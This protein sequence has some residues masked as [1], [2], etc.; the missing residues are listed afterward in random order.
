MKMFFINNKIF[1]FKYLN[2]NLRNIVNNE[3]KYF[4]RN[5]KKMNNLKLGNEN[6]TIN[7]TNKKNILED[8]YIKK[9]DNNLNLKDNK[10]SDLNTNNN[11]YFDNKNQKNDKHYNIDFSKDFEKYDNL[12]NNKQENNKFTK[13]KSFKQNYNKSFDYKEDF[14]RND[15]KKNK[16]FKNNYNRNNQD[17][18]FYNSNKYKNNRKEFRN[19]EENEEFDPVGFNKRK[20]KN[21][22][23]EKERIDT[24]RKHNKFEKNDRFS[25]NKHKYNDNFNE[26]RTKYKDFRNNNKNTYNNIYNKES[27]DITKDYNQDNMFIKK[28][29]EENSRYVKSK[30]DSYLN[31]EE[32]KE[33]DNNNIKN[34]KKFSFERKVDNKYNL[35]ITPNEELHANTNSMY[36][37]FDYLYGSHVVKA[38]LH[39]NLRN[40]IE[41]YLLENYANNPSQ[42]IEEILNLCK[43]NNVNIIPTN[44]SKLERLSGGKPNNGVV[45]K[46]EKKQYIDV[47]TIS[48]LYK[49]LINRYELPKSEN[50]SILEIEKDFNYINKN[51]DI[52]NQTINEGG[53]LVILIDQII[54]P[55]NFASI[56]RTAFYLGVDAIVVNKPNRLSLSP[57]ISK[58]SSGSLECMDIYCTKIKSFIKDAFV[59]NWTIIGSTIETNK[60]IIIKKGKELSSNEVENNSVDE[61]SSDISYENKLKMFKDLDTTYIDDIPI[62]KNSKVLLIFGSMSFEDNEDPKSKDN[63]NSYRCHY[64]T[65]IKSSYNSQIKDNLKYN[66]V[67]NLNV[68]VSAGIIINKV[69][70]MLTKI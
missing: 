67:D 63:C 24:N 42:S 34:S 32:N 19:K 38:T 35:L 60:D 68:G 37:S 66:V 6:V 12:S 27:N 21:I 39:T 53:K 65:E 33:S 55:Q 4:A 40:H 25:E 5:I 36:S 43:D 49:Y 20:K 23:S 47:K 14:D 44:K 62:N 46:T 17:N 54:D 57:L 18:E 26:E 8:I 28:K 31:N 30:I 10:F 45:L 22:L 29:L 59:N 3:V 13:H 51:K 56:L 50:K 69:K 48:S 7:E 70:D 9:M 15:S 1:N 16:G 41:L 52:Y 58:V 2:N 61:D 64:K 11:T